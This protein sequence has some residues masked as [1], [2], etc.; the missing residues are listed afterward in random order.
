MTNKVTHVINCAGR[1]IPNHWEPI[2]VRYLTYYWMDQEHQV[3]CRLNQTILDVSDK[4]ARETFNFIDNAISKGDSVLVHSVNG[5][6]R[7]GT[8]ITAFLMRKY[9]WSLQKT[10][11]FMLSRRPDFCIRP[12]FMH[13]LNAYEARLHK[14]G[15][16]AKTTDWNG[17]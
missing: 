9:R 11:Q 3:S 15:L 7:A 2:A 14:Q 17:K 4:V 12:A 10:V 16:G 5:L 1:Q 13:Q 6:N 8:I